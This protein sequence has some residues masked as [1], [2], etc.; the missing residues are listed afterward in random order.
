MGANQ[1]KTYNVSGK[2][3]DANSLPADQGIMC[4]VNQANGTDSNGG[5]NSSS[6]QFCIQ[7]SV[8]GTSFPVVTTKGG[9]TATPATGPEMLPLIS[10]IPGGLAGLFL[11]KKSVK[12]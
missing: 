8:L 9:L 5:V 12:K 1:T 3:V 4:I 2:I 11:R 10:L 7:K 6:S